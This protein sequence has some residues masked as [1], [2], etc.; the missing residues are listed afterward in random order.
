[1]LEICSMR[2]VNPAA[3]AGPRTRGNN[4]WFQEESGCAVQASGTFKARACAHQVGK[5]SPPGVPEDRPG[6]VPEDRTAY[7]LGARL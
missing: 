6:Q 1:M 3:A 5:A 7:P 2:V 4:T